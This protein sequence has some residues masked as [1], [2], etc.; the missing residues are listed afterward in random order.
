M[1]VSHSYTV[2]KNL[3][4]RTKTRY[5]FARALGLAVGVSITGTAIQNLLKH[6]LAN[7]DLPT[8]IAENITNY[9]LTL[10]N[11]PPSQQSFQAAVRLAIAKAHRNL[12]E[13]NLG[14]TVLALVLMLG[15]RKGDMDR[16]LVSK[17]RVEKRSEKELL[18]VE[19]GETRADS[20]T[21]RVDLQDERA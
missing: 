18:D 8:V 13:I 12:S 15:L 19:M 17:Q 9:I 3:E 2:T 4:L 5:S 10:N 6:W 14:I 11:L 1:Y 7:A 16:E 20:A 21:A